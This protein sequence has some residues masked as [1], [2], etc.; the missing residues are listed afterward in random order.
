MATISRSSAR[1][2]RERFSRSARSPTNSRNAFSRLFL[3]NAE[4]ERPAAGDC[5]TAQ[6]DPYF[7]DHVLFYEYFHGDTGRELRA[8]HQTGWTGLVANLLKP[9][10]GRAFF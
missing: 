1:P 6:H 5:E 7:K 3:R 4:G 9:D 10:Q 2:G 8:S